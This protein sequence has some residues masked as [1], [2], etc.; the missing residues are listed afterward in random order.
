MEASGSGLIN[1]TVETL[2][3]WGVRVVNLGGDATALFA[4]LAIL[5]IGIKSQ[6][7]FVFVCHTGTKRSAEAVK[8]AI[9]HDIPVAFKRG[10]GIADV[11]DWLSN[12]TVDE[13]GRCLLP[14]SDV[15]TEH[16]AVFL[17]SPDDHEKFRM[18][19]RLFQAQPELIG[20]L[21]VVFMIANEQQM[22]LVSAGADVIMPAYQR[23]WRGGKI[24]RHLW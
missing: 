4:E 18:V 24:L 9:E 14:G 6:I 3:S 12:I 11:S 8:F 17:E 22:R 16:I 21:T 15:P 13:K 1:G 2:K 23:N 19:M 20:R 7:G 10:V 5:P